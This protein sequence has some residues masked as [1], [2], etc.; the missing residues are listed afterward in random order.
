[1][2]ERDCL[3]LQPGAL[4]VREIVP[5]A[6]S[7]LSTVTAKEMRNI[8]IREFIKFV[9]INHHGLNVRSQT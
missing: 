3:R 8:S 5:Y 9:S 1:L 6:W 2:R 4:K 7:L